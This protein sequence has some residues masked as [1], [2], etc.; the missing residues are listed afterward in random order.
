MTMMLMLLACTATWALMALML[1]DAREGLLSALKGRPVQGGGWMPSPV[2]V[3]VGRDAS[4]A[5]SRA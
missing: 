2:R 1:G 3:S 4:R 5:F